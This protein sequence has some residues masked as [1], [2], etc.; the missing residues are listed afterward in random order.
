M[1]TGVQVSVG[2]SNRRKIR[3]PIP[4]KYVH[5]V[6]KAVVYLINLSDQTFTFGRT[7]GQYTILGCQ[8]GEEFTATEVRG[9]LEVM[10]EG[11]E[12]YGQQLTE[13]QDIAED[14]ASNANDHMLTAPD[15]DSFIG[16]FVS[17]T[18]PPPAKLLKSMQT[19]LLAFY[20]SQVQLADAFWDSPADHKQISSLHR[21]A[22]KA[23]GQTRPWTYQV[24]NMIECPGCAT[25]L[26]ATVAICKTCDAIIDETKA[27]KLYPWRFESAAASETPAQ[28]RT[29]PAPPTA[30]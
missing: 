19:R 1:P 6:T 30:A 10:D 4:A 14:L 8:D 15:G 24:T 26:P 11:D 23:T 7:Y 29:K 22:A 27:R 25:S 13:A 20:N 2:P 16:V 9:R 3:N 12:K 28:K 17:P 18:N 5:E 21:R